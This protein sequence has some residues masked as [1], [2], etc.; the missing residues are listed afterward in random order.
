MRLDFQTLVHTDHA[1]LT[2]W[3]Q[4]QKI[5]RRI[6]RQVLKLEE[7][8]IKLQHVPGKN[9]GHADALSRRPDYDQGTA[10]NQNVTVL[11]DKLFIR[12][13]ASQESNQD[14]EVLKPWVDPHKLKQISGT[15]WKNNQLVVTAD[16]PSRRT[17]VQMHHDPPAYGHPGISR[18]LELTARRYWWPHMA[19]D[20]KDYVKGCTHCQ[21]NKVNNQSK[22]APLNPI[23]AKPGALPFETIAMDF[24]VKL[25]LSNGF[26]SIL[27]ITDHN[28]TKAVILIPCNETITAEGVAK[29]Y[30]EHVFK[31]VG[32]P[33][34]LIHDQDTRFMSSFATK[35]CQALGIRQNASTVFHPRTDGQSERTNQKLEQ[36]L[37]FYSNARQ[38]NWAHFLSLAEFAINSWRNES[39]KKSPF[40]ILMGYNPRAEWTTVSSPVPQVTHCLE[41]I[42]EARDQ[43][44]IAMRKAQIGWVRDKEKNQH[45]FRKGDQVWLDGRNIK[46]YHLTA[47]LAPKRHWP[48]PIQRVLSTITYQLTLPEQWKIHDVFHVDLL[49]PYRETEF[50]GANYAC[51]PPDLVGEEE[52][53][54]V[55]QV[56]DE[57][58]YGCWKKKQ[59]LVKWKGYPDSD[60][61][62]LDAKDMENAQELIAEFHN[63]N[64]EVYSHI[65]RALGHLHV[66]HSPSSTLLS[67]LISMP[68]S[69]ASHTEPT[70]RVEENMTPLPIPPR[71]TTADAPKSSVRT[72]EQDTAIQERFAGLLRICED[73]STNVAGIRFPHPDEPTPSE[74]NDSDQENIPPPAPEIPHPNPTI[75]TPP[76]LGR[77]RHSIPFTDDVATNQALLA[78]I[79][80]VRNNVN[81]GNTYVE[82]IE[83]IVRIGHTLRHRG[84][85]SEDEEAAALVAR[86]GQ[87]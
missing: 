17:I 47:K 39:T 65:R 30:L 62:W 79:T 60:N 15:W 53:Y 11:P 29:L 58:N 23:F 54:K 21:R 16:I 59:Y 22:R 49:T 13:L 34:T 63:S 70:I 61:Q 75:Q 55:E 84:S 69:N 1:N 74:L 46:T 43:A 8:N 6:A 33:K 31:R 18:T 83:E 40:E 68:M 64:H 76:P 36:F 5:S 12:A 56:L 57:R 28:C 37:C 48:F 4:P 35:K 87:I 51:P 42:Q 38:D 80:R 19:Q 27:T 67:T 3:R 32:L 86:L 44:G 81:R 25:P 26:N 82:Q 20:V 7:Y 9:N 73:G 10:D 24:I 77:T 52:E 45:T 50:H 66:L 71:S 78:A 41:Q 85:P 2:Y 72:S 14:E